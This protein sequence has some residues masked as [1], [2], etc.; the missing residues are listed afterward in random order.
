MHKII[1][2][3]VA[4]GRPQNRM[5]KRPRIV[6]VINLY[7]LVLKSFRTVYYTAY[8][9]AITGKVFEYSRA[10]DFFFFNFILYI[11]RITTCEM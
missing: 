7:N 10:Y 6:I 8:L 11:P 5:H 1:Y 4:D 3:N 9:S 2:R